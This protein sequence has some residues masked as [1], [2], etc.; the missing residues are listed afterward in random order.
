MYIE[1]V[2]QSGSALGGREH[3]PM[4]WLLGQPQLRTT[5][6]PLLGNALFGFAIDATTGIYGEYALFAFSAGAAPITMPSVLPPAPAG[7]C[8]QA[9]DPT[10]L[11]ALWLLPTQIVTTH[12]PLSLANQ[13]PSLV[14]T[15]L[16]AQALVIDLLPFSYLPYQ[17]I[18]NALRLTF[19][20]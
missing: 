17:G 6:Q 14:G 11:L 8:R 4:A 16:H 7:G 9:I 15:Q 5:S 2:P 1:P 18:T 20:Q 10:L 3:V 12:V 19:G 13:S